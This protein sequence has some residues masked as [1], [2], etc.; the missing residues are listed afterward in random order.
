MKNKHNLFAGLSAL[1]LPFRFCAVEEDGGGDV[2]PWMKS[3]LGLADDAVAD[4][5][6]E[7][8]KEEPEPK[9]GQTGM[10]LHQ[11]I[12]EPS[13]EDKAEKAAEET[14]A[15]EKAKAEADKAAAEKV[16]EDTP[17]K[18]VK[19]SKVEKTAPTAAEI[20]SAT[21]NAASAAAAAEAEKKSK[22]WE[23]SLLDEE[24]D[25]L[26]IARFAERANPGKYKGY[27]EKT[28]K[29]LRDHAAKTEAEDFDPDS[30]EYKA[31][32]AKERPAM[33]NTEIRI[34]ERERGAE[35]AREEA[36]KHSNEVLDKTFRAMEAPAVKRDADAYFN[37]A[38]TEVLP[39]E[40]AK[41][42]KESPAKAREQYPL[43]Y[44]IVEK[45]L[46]SHTN[47]VEEMFLLTRSNPDTGRT[48]KAFDEANPLHMQALKLVNDTDAA[49]KRSGGAD[50]VRN[51]RRFLPRTELARVPAADRGKYWTFT[52]KEIADRSTGLVKA[53]I[54]QQINSESERLKK[55]GFERRPVAAAAAP[56]KAK[57]SPPAPRPS[58]NT[59]TG[60]A[61]G[62]AGD[63][64]MSSFFGTA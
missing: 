55:L 6:A 59:G 10:T 9:A 27:A 11:A 33:S 25:Q 48:L 30:D 46:D 31:W 41:V 43:E 15:A 42:F 44:E 5:A 34:L 14:A 64:L 39:D 61:A 23:S 26:E 63:N 58:V 7:V 1:L 28:A 45:A 49:F 51:G 52:S 3:L 29:F 17:I 4:P 38:S 20:V 19:R 13:E 22:D 2:S 54:A 21:Q 53:Q 47:V 12:A 16:V 60:E 40:V 57:S 62:S 35:T 37:K 56:A 36:R 24:K 8:V 50:L 18:V 32:L